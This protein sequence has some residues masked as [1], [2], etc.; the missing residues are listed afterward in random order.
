MKIEQATDSASTIDNSWR[1]DAAI[2]RTKASTSSEF[3]ETQS[4][5]SSESSHS[6]LD[7]TEVF[8]RMSYTLSDVAEEKHT[9]P[10]PDHPPPPP[11][12]R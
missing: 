1:S 8:P 2:A 12:T 4:L 3:I 11:T 9:E 7:L 5:G 6:S 10:I